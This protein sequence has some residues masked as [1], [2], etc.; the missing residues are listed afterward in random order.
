[1]G[2]PQKTVKVTAPRSATPRYLTTLVEWQRLN[3]PY[4]W[5]TTELNECWIME[6]LR[7]D[8]VIGCVWLHYAATGD[9][10]ECHGSS[11]KGYESRWLT[12]HTLDRMFHVAIST[13]AAYMIAQINSP[14]LAS[15]WSRLGGRIL[16]QIM[17]LP[18]KELN[19]GN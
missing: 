12:P 7:G 2:N 11:T 10:I 19:D 17:I 1:M 8:V 4:E 18:L 13:G 5:S 16:D 6:V 9:V 3:H 14:R 15:M